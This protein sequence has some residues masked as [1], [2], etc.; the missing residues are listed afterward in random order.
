MSQLTAFMWL[1]L[2]LL[3]SSISTTL[4]RPFSAATVSGVD[5]FYSVEKDSI[6]IQYIIQLAKG[7]V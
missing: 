6:F 3:C 1:T 2:A 7:S 5:C 4:A